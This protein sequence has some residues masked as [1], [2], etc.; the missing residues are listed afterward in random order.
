LLHV[1]PLKNI[2]EKNVGD[3]F[4]FLFNKSLFLKALCDTTHLAGW[5][6]GT[7]W[8]AGWEFAH[9]TPMSDIGCHEQT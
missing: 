6:A 1:T 5:L 4:C 9:V 2:D 3:S 7:G 8:L